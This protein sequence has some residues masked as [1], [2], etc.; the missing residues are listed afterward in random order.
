MATSSHSLFRVTRRH[1]DSRPFLMR[2]NRQVLT[3]D[4]LVD[5]VETGCWLV[6]DQ[7][8]WSMHQRTQ[9]GKFVLHARAPVA[10]AL[11]A[12]FPQVDMLEQFADACGAVG[13]GQMPDARVQ[14]QILDGAQ[15]V[16]QPR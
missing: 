11:I 2:Q 7:Q 13:G 9:D 12:L 15:V 8:C 5:R 3:Q 14:F 10:D 4:F 1:Q 16:V 6:Q